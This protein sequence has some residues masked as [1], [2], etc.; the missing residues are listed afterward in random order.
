MLK[1]FVELPEAELVYELEFKDENW[2]MFQR[3]DQWFVQYTQD[4]H[5]EIDMFHSKDKATNRWENIK[6]HI[7]ERTRYCSECGTL[8]DETSKNYTEHDPYCGNV[9]GIAYYWTCSKCGREEPR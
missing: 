8:M 9:P 4:N 2:R 1:N 5:V 7:K 3:Y 6:K